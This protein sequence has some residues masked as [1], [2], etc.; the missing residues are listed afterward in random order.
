MHHI[1]ISNLDLQESNVQQIN[2]DD[3][4]HEIDELNVLIEIEKESAKTSE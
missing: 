3:I 2:Y 1:P 4:L